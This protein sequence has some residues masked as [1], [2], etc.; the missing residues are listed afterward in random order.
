MSILFIYIYQQKESAMR[1]QNQKLVI[2]QLEI[3][4]KDI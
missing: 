3:A 1:K 4:E 2:E